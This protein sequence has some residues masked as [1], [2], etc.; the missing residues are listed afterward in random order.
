MTPKRRQKPKQLGTLI[1]AGLHGVL[2]AFCERLGIPMHAFVSYVIWSA[3]R[4]VVPGKLPRTMLAD[5][6]TI[7][8]IKTLESLFS[9]QEGK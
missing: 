3:L 4:E 5:S 1:P 2:K 7:H 9:L 6:L 8:E